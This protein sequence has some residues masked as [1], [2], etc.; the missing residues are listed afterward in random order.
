[1]NHQELQPTQTEMFSSP[2]LRIIESGRSRRPA[3]SAPLREMGISAIA[4]TAGGLLMHDSLYPRE[5]HWIIGVTSSLLI[6]KTSAFARSR[7]ME[8]S[9]GWP[10][11]T[12]EAL[13]VTAGPP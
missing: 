4:V 7:R 13:A 9:Q 2:I 11:T 6:R 10:A 5:W 1:M 3:L 12:P 8:P